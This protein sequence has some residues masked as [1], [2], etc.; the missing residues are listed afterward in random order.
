[1]AQQNEIILNEITTNEGILDD[2]IIA[3]V[4]D[5]NGY[6]WFGTRSGLVRFDGIKLENFTYDPDLPDG[7]SGNNILG[8]HIDK[9]DM[10]WIGTINGLCRFDEKLDRPVKIPIKINGQFIDPYI[11]EISS[12]SN[13]LIWI[14]TLDDGLISYD[15]NLNKSIQYL[16]SE[17]DKNGLLSNRLRRLYSTSDGMLWICTDKGLNSYDQEKQ[18]FK[19]YLHEKGNP[20][21]ISSNSI[22]SISE[23]N[24]GD[25]WLG[26]GDSGLDRFNPQKGLIINYKHKKNNNS[27][28][29]NYVRSVLFNDKE[30]W[31]GSGRGS[32]GLDRL[33]LETGIVENFNITNQDQRIF[34]SSTNEIFIDKTGIVWIARSLNGIK[35]FDPALKNYK[36]YLIDNSGSENIV[37]RIY[38]ITPISNTEVWASTFDGLVLFDLNHG[39]QKHLRDQGDFMLMHNNS[40][41]VNNQLWIPSRERGIV[42]YNLNSEKFTYINQNSNN[43]KSLS[44]NYVN[45]LLK[46]KEGI[47]WSGSRD[48]GLDRIDPKTNIIKRYNHIPGNSESLPDNSVYALF[49]FNENELWIGTNGGLGLFNKKNETFENFY[50]NPNDTSSLS[51]QQVSYILKSKNGTFWIAS[52]GGGLNKFDPDKK[53]FQRFTFPKK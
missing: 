21:S 48:G 28:N 31:I 13:G 20:K 7:L 4:Q 47:V 27:I 42:K 33:D 25:L 24:N 18:L 40:I 17:N 45:I 16:H 1:M 39:V 3:I 49:E 52:Y 46:D 50:H 10:L 35:Y 6:M 9:N 23:G 5:A 51:G 30:V 8:L 38:G 53:I 11:Q 26:T 44:S 12:S 41:S 36:Q 32:D 2:V 14:A 37:N 43:E 34:G 19:S 29:G 15:P 22:L